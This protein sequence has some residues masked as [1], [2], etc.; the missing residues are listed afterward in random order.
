M[1]D[2]FNFNKIQ[3]GSSL[4]MKSDS[5]G[6]F[7]ASSAKTDLVIKSSSEGIQHFTD[8]DAIY[9]SIQE[10]N[11]ARFDDA[12]PNKLNFSSYD[13]LTKYEFSDEWSANDIKILDD[14]AFVAYKDYTDI[15]RVE[16]NY[17]ATSL[18]QY[19]FVEQ[20][21]TTSNDYY[22]TFQRRSG[23][24]L[25]DLT[26]N[27]DL[28]YDSNID[29]FT[30][31]DV[32]NAIAGYDFADRSINLKS[33]ILKIELSGTVNDGLSNTDDATKTNL[34]RVMYFLFGGFIDNESAYP[35]LN[36]QDLKYNQVDYSASRSLLSNAIGSNDSSYPAYN[37]LLDD[38]SQASYSILKEKLNQ[39]DGG[40]VGKF[41]LIPSI[42]TDGKA[43]T[44]NFGIQLSIQSNYGLDEKFASIGY[45][46]DGIIRTAKQ[47][48]FFT[49]AFKYSEGALTGYRYHKIDVS[50]ATLIKFQPVRKCGKV[51]IYTKKKGIA[52][53]VVGNKIQSTGHDLSTN[54]IIEI[55]SALYSESSIDS[56]TV[57]K[58][59]MNGKKFVKIVDDDNFEIYED[60]F[61]KDPT[62]T[63]NLRT[64]DGI[65]WSCVAN[66]FGSLS[67]SWNYH[68]TMFSPTGR[69]GYRNVSGS[70]TADS[71]SEL[72]SFFTTKRTSKVDDS[73]SSES[74]DRGAVNLDFTIDFNRIKNTL[75]AK[76]IDEAVPANFTS[77]QTPLKE[78]CR[79]Y[80]D[81][82]PYNCQD[83]ESDTK[84]NR[85]PYKGCKFGSSIDFKFS[86]KSGNSKVYTLAIGEPA[87]DIS[88]D[89]FGLFNEDGARRAVISWDKNIDGGVLNE[90]NTA[91]LISRRRRIPWH[92]PYGRV[93]LFTVTVDQYNNITDLSHQN[94]VFGGGYD[95][96]NGSNVSSYIEKN[97]WK[98]F[99][100]DSRNYYRD[101][102]YNPDDQG[103]L[104]RINFDEFKESSYFSELFS[105]TA[106]ISRYWIRAAV[107][108]WYLNPIR[109]F[110][111]NNEPSSSM[112]Y[113]RYTDVNKLGQTRALSS[114]TS[115]INDLNIYSRFGFAGY[116][117][118]VPVYEKIDRFKVDSNSY[119][120]ADQTFKFL[121]PWVDSFGKSVALKNDSLLSS[122]S[123]SGFN[124]EDPKTILVAGSTARS[125]IEINT[126][127]NQPVLVGPEYM[128]EN[129]CI[130]Q[131]G[132]LTALY[133]YKDTEN[134]YQLVDFTEINSGGSNSGRFFT[135]VLTGN[136][137][138]TQYKYLPT[139]YDAGRG[140][141]EVIV[142]CHLSASQIEFVGNKLVWSDQ[143]LYN[144]MSTLN[145]LEYD[146]SAAQVFKPYETIS[147]NFNFPR[148]AINPST[149]VTTAYNTG[150]GFGFHFKFND[151]L[152]ITN[153]MDTKTDLDY[154]LSDFTDSVKRLDCLYL[155]EF[156]D[157]KYKFAQKIS[158]SINEKN[159][160]YPKNL[161]E[162]FSDY[163]LSIPNVNYDNT[164]KDTLTWNIDLT[165]RYDI[166]GGRILLK[167]P[168]EY[169]LFG[170]DFS[171]KESINTGE[172]S[173]QDC[174][175]YLALYERV[176]L[177]PEIYNTNEV[178]EKTS[179]LVY[180]YINESSTSFLVSDHAGETSEQFFSYTPL[181][182][183]NLPLEDLDTP[184][185][186][187][188]RF[189]VDLSEN[190]STF[191][192]FNGSSF[193]SIELTNLIPRIVLY[194]QDPRSTVVRNGPSSTG[195]KTS[196]FPQYENGL[197]TRIPDPFAEDGERFSYEYPG[198][199]R[200]GAKDLYFY[201][202]LP[203]SQIKNG[204]VS[205]PG[206][207]MDGYLYGGESNLGD[208]YDDTAGTRGG[209]YPDTV[210]GDP[211]F[212]SPDIYQELTDAQKQS[213][214]PYAKIFTPTSVSSV[215]GTITLIL[216]ITREDFEQFLIDGSV[217]KDQ[218][219]AT[220]NS[221]F[222]DDFND[223]QNLFGT[224]DTSEIKK[225]LIVGFHLTNITDFNINT[226]QLNY[227]D[228]PTI[229]PGPLKYILEAEDNNF[230]YVNARYPYCY[231][232]LLYNKSFE[233]AVWN[234]QYL[235]YSMQ[236]R[237]GSIEMILGKTGGFSRRYANKFHKVAVFEYDKETRDDI[238]LNYTSS[239][240]TVERDTY[241]SFGFDRFVPAVTSVD[242][243]PIISIARL[244]DDKQEKLQVLNSE[245]VDSVDSS[246][247]IDPETG[248]LEY[249]APPTG[250]V[251]GTAYFNKYALLGSFDISNEKYLPLFVKANP[252]EDDGINLQTEGFAPSSGNMAL[253][254]IP[255]SVQSSNANLFI[256]QTTKTNAAPLFIKN[257]IAYQASPLFV[258][259]IQPS[260]TV[261][262][263]TRS[264]DA[265][266]G[267]NLIMNPQTS[268][269]MPLNI[270]APLP[271]SGGIPLVWTEYQ[272]NQGPLFIDGVFGFA[273]GMP[274]YVDGV[275]G[276]TGS[277]TLTFSP[278]FSG[279]TPLTIG[280]R[281]ASGNMSLMTLPHDNTN[282]NISLYTRTP[283]ENSTSLYI[284]N[285]TY[286]DS[287]DLFV[288]GLDSFTD[289]GDLFVDGSSG[290][291]ITSRAP[292]FI[293]LDIDS[294]QQAPLFIRS[295]SGGGGSRGSSG[296]E[297][298]F[299]FTNLDGW[300]GD[301][302]FS[303]SAS[304]GRLDTY[305]LFVDDNLSGTRELTLNDG[306][307]CSE[308][309]TITFW[310]RIANDEDTYANFSLVIDDVVV[311]N[312]R[313]VGLLNIDE[314][315]TT[316]WQQYSV[317]VSSGSHT[318]KLRWIDENDPGE[319]YID[320][321]IISEPSTSISYNIYGD[322]STFNISGGLNYNSTGSSP[323][324]MKVPS[325]GDTNNSFD[326]FVKVDEP[327]I[328]VG[329]GIL[330]SGNN[331][332]Y[333]DG[334]ND[335][336]IY[337]QNRSNA[338]L[339]LR[340]LPIETQ[341]APL[342]IDRPDTNII[343]LYINSSYDSGNINVYISGNYTYNDSIGLF[344]KSPESNDF[345]FFLRGYLE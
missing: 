1:Q 186:L 175:P 57:S 266:S 32:Q 295:L 289:S 276:K 173:S 150:D 86:H 243:N 27:Q 11:L 288:N 47:S 269:V 97:P 6:I 253:L 164:S 201:G 213:I 345:K 33:S 282:Q 238:R 342:Y 62:D 260:S 331:A 45:L 101:I 119:T 29:Q 53:S 205:I 10:K 84:L 330:T 142:S 184:E 149:L 337:Y 159:S 85:S 196:S 151:K 280:A 271:S 157:D 176:K 258:Y 50:N 14:I 202:K 40:V 169:S 224:V 214:I 256:G 23:L 296:S 298:I 148:S 132:Q 141:A 221:N 74:V 277:T 69:N 233:G 339:Y 35:I 81:F 261:P 336:G 3:G 207:V 230:N 212:V 135:N 190:I 107:V 106:N 335:A 322:I 71:L 31:T 83:S 46:P 19:A 270:R 326:A 309:C 181:F 315:V 5:N 177:T 122:G 308:E 39:L 51:D 102:Y 152:F 30:N 25:G 111:D 328:G 334:N 114:T 323:L 218:S 300:S 294:D 52:A 293:G 21:Y 134:K 79:F 37:E 110:R 299:T 18:K 136:K 187:R 109:K 137:L 220:A 7:D 131:I 16:V 17:G 195:T 42:L 228:I 245:S 158:A 206:R 211:A 209:T 240:N 281:F 22:Y 124:S 55:S 34:P 70:S 80:T 117:S 223:S 317:S 301:S 130:S 332:L 139:G 320:D 343:P 254:T 279:V 112:G 126:Q 87:S 290:S 24:K 63:S 252:F 297:T 172:S 341:T 113:Y 104:S 73:V 263:F 306:F 198:W 227:T 273:S 4:F 191:E 242:K 59:P 44:P 239:V 287:H 272:T 170:R 165:G 20:F 13:D 88:V 78:L 123:L 127:L 129:D 229:N 82:Y 54:D 96:L 108:S 324:F 15:E 327:I 182:Y 26:I 75:F 292:L 178:I 163:V 8:W 99:E 9:S 234:G 225:T 217:I 251:L 66:N 285:K 338:P 60:Q 316:T 265:A 188:I 262:L 166:V 210:A 291:G 89:L 90:R 180:R 303:V 68:G 241:L 274:N 98:Q 199:Y 100:I 64:T 231:H 219:R 61:F 183:F 36:Y 38:E 92:L 133:L 329:G 313:G 145:V 318:L 115:G 120:A 91:Y 275:F 246:Y 144:G 93:H 344:I 56:F 235:N 194:G 118:N 247:F 162:E 284:I 153:T 248:E 76:K 174:E 264:V 125:N 189:S 314:Q 160:V 204:S 128:S 333:V 77:Y 203:G 259:E 138:G 267:I 154:N 67:Q 48:S 216:D 179:Q 121:F 226:G 250:A 208:Y 143:R 244:S 12:Q 286:Y 222:V 193:Q 200:G 237:I 155:Y 41:Y 340:A 146:D 249:N 140:L 161:S 58:H 105:R 236:S 257:Q 232:S 325:T 168:I 65:T 43:S 278:G 283:E 167:D 307:S 94:T 319:L 103:D 321:L 215:D 49:D 304:A 116:G 311:K 310:A 192:K 95:L 72:N 312:I 305:G 185:T 147:R 197:Y 28:I 302:N 268:G 255:K 171:K 156:L 2:N